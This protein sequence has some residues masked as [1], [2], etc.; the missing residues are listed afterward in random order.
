MKNLYLNIWGHKIDTTLLSLFEY[1]YLL[2]FEN[3]QV[4][5]LEDM[6]IEMDRIWEEFNLDNKKPFTSQKIGDYYSHPVWIL[7]GLFSMSNSDSVKHRSLISDYVKNL[8]KNTLICDFGGGFGELAIKIAEQNKL[9]R[10]TILEPYFSKI[11]F[12]RIVGLENIEIKSQFENH[13]DII[14]AQDVLEHVEDPINLSKT[15][16][17]NLN[18]NGY[19]IFA[20][21]FHPFIKAH[22]PSNFHLA[23]SF[24]WIMRSSGL[25][26][27]QSIPGASH[28]EVYQK[29]G[30]YNKFIISLK[31]I[32]SQLFFKIRNL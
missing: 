2:K 26:F 18:H 12:S 1:N 17:D 16:I 6:W 30:H 19:I 27:I 32:F 31:I 10:V 3:Q 21:C 4:L 7:N 20:N 9:S 14:I 28:I 13:F 23:R 29:N 24:K 25:K 15:L 11:G 5:D 22:L 8:N